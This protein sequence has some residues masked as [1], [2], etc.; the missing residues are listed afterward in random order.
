MSAYEN[1]RA[2][3]FNG[4][5]ARVSSF[6]KGFASNA[7]KRRPHGTPTSPPSP[8]ARHSRRPHTSPA[9]RRTLH[10]ALVALLAC[11]LVI[12]VTGCSKEQVIDSFDSVIQAGGNL[13]L[14]R[15]RDLQGTRDFG[16]DHY[17]GT[18]EADYD[19]FYGTE[20]LFGGTALQRD[21]GSVVSLR[22]SFDVSRGSGRLVLRSGDQQDVVLV[23][24]TGSYSGQITLAAGSNYI[25]LEGTGLSGSVDLQIE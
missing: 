11:C 24:G 23:D 16:A 14:T 15:E 7:L 13:I 6:F 17:T 18:Y 1:A 10:L 21:G 12:P 8:H 5:A 25:V 22:C 9:P 4:K 3:Q 19:D 20:V 2:V